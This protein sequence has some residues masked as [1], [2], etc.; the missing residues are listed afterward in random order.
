M[1]LFDFSLRIGW[2]VEIPF[3]D[4]ADT[5]IP[6]TKELKIIDHLR[7]IEDM[8]PVR[9]DALFDRDI[10]VFDRSHE[11][12]RNYLSP[13][14]REFHKIVFI[15]EGAGTFIIGTNIYHI[16]QPTIVFIHPNE[17]VSWQNV[18]PHSKATGH[19]CLFRK[20]F[21][22]E[23][24]ALRDMVRKYSLFS[25][26]GR[27][28]IK[29]L[30]EEVSRIDGLFVQMH[31]DQNVENPFNHDVLQAYL[32]LIMSAS[33]QSAVDV[34]PDAISKEY[35]H[36]YEFFE[37]LESEFSMAGRAL[38]IRLKTAKEFA[39]ALAVHPSHLNALLKKNTGQT[40]STHI[41]NRLLEES[42]ALLMQTDWTL[43][44]ISYVTGFTEQPAFSLF[45]KKN[46][47]LTPAEFRRACH[48]SAKG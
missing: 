33:Q 45:F 44:Q 46:A 20:T 26:G 6:V 13:S 17:I 25:A 9:R 10:L 24:P 32:Q 23:Y 37:L 28:V 3:I 48:S 42:K 41:K 21:I 8:M 38:P 7:D 19:F 43:Q 31:R 27:N 47:G 5:L 39:Q 16:N 11:P 34:L 35:R 14:R 18:G 36:I 29:L 2:F 15:N 4:N 30:P 40:V 1:T 22:D 12:C